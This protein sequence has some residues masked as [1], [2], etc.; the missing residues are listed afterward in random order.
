[1][2]FIKSVNERFGKDYIILWYVNQELGVDILGIFENK[3][4]MDIFILNYVNSELAEVYDMME[5]KTLDEDIDLDDVEDYTDE[6]DENGHYIFINPNK[7]LEWI[8]NKGHNY[9]QNVWELSYQRKEMEKPVLDDKI[10][11]YMEIKKYNL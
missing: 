2:K 10:K 11:E 4:D 1:M 8:I 3:K 9:I 6:K 5:M 7:A